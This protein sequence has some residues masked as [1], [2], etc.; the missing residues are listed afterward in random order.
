MITASQV[1]VAATPVVLADVP[2]GPC[3]VII[4]NGGSTAVYV[5]T[6]SQVTSGN[7]APVPPGGVVTFSGFPGSRAVTL[8]AVGESTAV[9]AGVVTVTGG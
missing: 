7:G 5:G 9:P 1:S 2:P 8:W 4:T 6:S 3:Q